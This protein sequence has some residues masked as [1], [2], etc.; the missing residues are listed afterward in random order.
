MPE[1]TTDQQVTVLKQKITTCY[2][3]IAA[4]SAEA[5]AVETDRIK[6]DSFRGK[7][8]MLDSLFKDAVS[9]WEQLYEL[10]LSEGKESTFPYEEKYLSKIKSYASDCHAVVERFM[11]PVPSATSNTS[12][13]VGQNETSVLDSSLSSFNRSKLPKIQ[14]PTFNGDILRWPQFRDLFVSLIH[15]EV[16]IG[17]VEKFQHLIARLAG[18]PLQIVSAFPISDLNY[19]E[20]WNALKQRYDNKRVLGAAYMQ[21]IRQFKSSTAQTGTLSHLRSFLKNV[22]ENFSAIKALGITNEADF[23][24]LHIA[25]ETLHPEIRQLYEEK[26]QGQ[27]FPTYESLIEFIHQ[28]CQILELADPVTPKHSSDRSPPN[29][30]RRAKVLTTFESK[31]PDKSHSQEQRN[32]EQCSYCKG[33]HPLFRCFSFRRLPT[34]EKYDLAKNNQLCFNCLRKGHTSIRCNSDRLCLTCKEKHHSALHSMFKNANL[35]T[36]G[37]ALKS[38]RSAQSVTA[39]ATT[40][41]TPSADGLVGA[42]AGRRTVLLGTAIV[43]IRD[44]N[45]INQ[46]I[47]IVIDSGSQFSVI[48]TECVER[49]GFQL[50]PGETTLSGIGLVQLSATR[51]MVDCQISP[52]HDNAVTLETKA[53]VMPAITSNLPTISLNP[54]L[55][56]Y[57]Q[58]MQLADPEFWESKPIDF[59]LGSDLFLQILVDEHSSRI[60]NGFGALPTI[61]GHVVMGTPPDISNR[62][63]GACLSITE[64]QTSDQILRDFW[65]IEEASV[66]DYQ[67][68]DDVKCEEHFK[69]NHLRL[70]SG[71]YMVALPLRHPDKRFPNTESQAL[72]RFFS[73]ESKFSRNVQLKKQYVEFMED[74]LAL[75]H[76]EATTNSSL[77]VIPHHAVFKQTLDHIPQKKI[78]VV[79]DASMKAYTGS[80]ND[81]LFIGKKLQTD[82]VS[83]LLNFRCHRIAF[84]TDIVKMFRQILVRPED[85][86]FQHIF[87]RPSSEEALQKYEL[88]T[89]TYGLASS[90]FLALRVLQQLA[91]DEGYRFPRAAR[92]LKH[93]VYVDDIITGENSFE[94][95]LELKNEI[96]N[97]LETAGF[98]VHK[99]ATNSAELLSTI[100]ETPESQVTFSPEESTTK[101]LG[102]IWNAE[103]D[104]F[105]YHAELTK[106][107]ITKR[108][109]LSVIARLYD[110][111]GLLAPVVFVAKSMLQ[112]LWALKIGWDDT[113]PPDIIRTWT[114]FT[115]DLTNV[116]TLSIP[117]WICLPA[118]EVSLFGFCDAS[119]K[120]YAAAIYIRTR[121]AEGQV[122]T[123]LL[124]SKT[125]LAPIKTISI[126]KLELCAAHLLTNLLRPLEQFRNENHVARVWLFTDSTIVLSWLQQDPSSLKTFVSNRVG[127]ILTYTMLTQWRHVPSAQNPADIASRG[128]R[129]GGLID[130][131]LW[132]DGPYWMKLSPVELPLMPPALSELPEMKQINR[133]LVTTEPKEHLSSKI[134][135]QY[136]SFRTVVRVVAYVMRFCKNIQTRDVNC[137]SLGPLSVSELNNA[138]NYLLKGTQRTFFGQDYDFKTGLNTSTRFKSLAVFQ[139][140]TGLLRVGGRLTNADLPNDTKHPILLPPQAPLTALIIDHCHIENFHLSPKALQAN[141]Q[142]QYYIFSIKSLIRKRVWSCVRCF[143]MRAKPDNP[144]M[145]DLPWSRVSQGRPFL[146]VGVDFAGPYTIKL[147]QRRNSPTSKAYLCVFVCMAVKAVHLELVS[148]LTTDAFLATLDRF[149]SRRGL[150]SDIY[151]DC[152]TNFVGA[153][154]QLKELYIWFNSN[155]VEESIA[156]YASNKGVQWHFNPPS[157][158]HFGGLWEA[159][160][161]SAKSLL[162]KTLGERAFFFEELT[163]L[164]ARIEAILNSRPLCTVST[165]PLE[166]DYL[167]PGH[168]LIGSALTALPE[169]DLTDTQVNRLTRWQLIQHASQVFW[170][171]W[172]N[173]YI[174]TLQSRTKWTNTGRSLEPG[175][176][177]LIQDANSSPLNW[178]LGR[179]EELHPGKDSIARVATIRTS[180]GLL[181]RPVHRLAILPGIEQN[182]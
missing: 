121:G 12:T 5:K 154:R 88:A 34:S 111:L 181:K 10:L 39:A 133:I 53:V 83:I 97:M 79:F 125:R 171:R 44:Y 77:Y 62:E 86:R 168:F 40:T 56:T 47:R 49:L 159:A 16:G 160:V 22:A 32:L 64:C 69:T 14:I 6:F 101:V 91:E 156:N 172:S 30:M 148:A 127:Y 112:S 72:R 75:G 113:P 162:L 136:S 61:F 123:F 28:R 176:L 71:R 124:K 129:I 103:Y 93:D 118:A 166:F 70:P 161:K 58:N 135:S 73:L 122:C 145:A 43:N 146:T 180:N 52:L 87:W 149:V 74:Y 99:W 164:F 41:K 116:S 98:S 173:E 19:T 8:K 36:H 84:C 90:P 68:P 33:A 130:N 65:E 15:N 141:L 59:L 31:A 76:M 137:K 23:F 42:T 57:F 45:G 139:D 96:I 182:E 175:E 115:D 100:Q 60:T 21:K 142:R 81:N 143:K 89:L 7:Y 55:H 178:K 20:A 134:I 13:Q 167:T 105:S 3:D 95:A 119:E 131:S 106:A 120:G 126:P 140:Q 27:E 25:L 46:R 17:S 29:I 48:T 82:I 35:A 54:L 18:E 104:N 117:R 128:Q 152:G 138:T 155:S 157:A 37:Q 78:R 179:I 174:H 170:R 177:V 80:L 153:A 144:F 132:W 85:R 51:G 165:K 94:Q 1:L 24:K 109:M 150:P 151:S 4:M 2:K 110:P 26:Q 147:S 92:V 107:D 63:K 50:S 102:M 9:A 67:H 38:S 114:E 158:P 108:S 163:T 11:N 169:R 66:S